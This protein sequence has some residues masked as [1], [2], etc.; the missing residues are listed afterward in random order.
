MLTYRYKLEVAMRVLSIALLL[1]S[2]PA[3]AATP[4]DVLDRMRHAMRADRWATVEQVGFVGSVQLGGMSG[5]IDEVSSTRDARRVTHFD[6]SVM[7]GSSGYD[8]KNIWSADAAG[9]VDVDESIAG[10]RNAITASFIANRLY[11]NPKIAVS[12]PTLRREGDHDVVTFAPDGGDALELWIDAYTHLVARAVI[13]GSNESTT[14]F[15]YR[16]VAGLMLP[17]RIESDDSSNNP[18]SI[19]VE[20]YRTSDHLDADRFVKPLS[21]ATDTAIADTPRT[22]S[23]HVEG[24]HVY[25]EASI[26]DSPPALF[27]LDTGASVNVL[28]PQAAKMFGVVAQGNLNATG[29]GES[30]VRVAL[31]TIS[32][33]RVGPATL[34]Q[35]MFAIIPLPSI[36][37]TRNDRSEPIAGLLGYDFF[38]RMRVTIDYARQTV[39]LAPLR[40]CSKRTT[41]AVPLYLDDGRIPRIPLTIAGVNALWTLDVGDAGSLT[42]SATVAEQ[43][44]IPSSAGIATMNE[45]GVGGVTRSRLLQLNELRIG[46]FQLPDP[47]VA[48]SDQKTGAFADPKFAG[49]VGY[50]TLRHFVPT[51]DYE[52][53]TLEITKSP[54]FGTPASYNAAGITWR[55]HDDGTWRVLH[56]MPNSPAAAA[57]LQIDDALISIDDTAAPSLTRAKIGELQSRQPGT[58]LSLQV[59]RET[60]RL[61]FT[62]K[63][64]RFVPRFQRAVGT[65]TDR[66]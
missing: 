52:C 7:G 8:G 4:S 15:D 38:R 18:Q 16:D 28:T 26:N 47:I 1:F 33:V 37:A 42:M 27:I 17:H 25:V 56:V 40:T 41:S 45:G 65:S 2:I 36:S 34:R 48:I 29:V 23:A 57:G 14:W 49:N 60:E 62:L 54:L 9:L 50:G 6:L 43:L 21:H 46:P 39:H 35:Q 19:V 13:P 32:S 63:L 31:A 44:A 55:Q 59:R 10:K 51:F 66:Q 30:Q 22:L 3:F 53:R 5:R 61:S 20:T 64:R 12:A 58:E 11:L 24:G